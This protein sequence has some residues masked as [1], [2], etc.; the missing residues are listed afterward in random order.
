MV[1]LINSLLLITSTLFSQWSP[2]NDTLSLGTVPL[3]LHRLHVNSI[4][5]IINKYNVVQQSRSFLFSPK[6]YKHILEGR[7]YRFQSQLS[8]WSWLCEFLIQKFSMASNYSCRQMMQN[9]DT[10]ARYWYVCENHLILAAM[11]FFAHNHYN[12]N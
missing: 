8:S 1:L 11:A 12:N 4:N 3:K 5:Y 9:Y 2:C 10:F 7:R 6:F